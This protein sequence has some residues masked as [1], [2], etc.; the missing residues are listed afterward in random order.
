M[1]P[2]IFQQVSV[3]VSTVFS[4]L[5]Q[6]VLQWHVHDIKSI[7]EWLNLISGEFIEVNIIHH[8]SLL[9]AFSIKQNTIQKNFTVK[10]TN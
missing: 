5:H 4:S 9:T 8:I 7:T 6:T 10:S 1:S 3:A 2:H